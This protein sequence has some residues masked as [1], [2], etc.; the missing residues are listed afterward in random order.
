MKNINQ[1]K[2]FLLIEAAFFIVILG[3]CL[4]SLLNLF[5]NVLSSS[6]AVE[7]MNTATMLA[8]SK[9]EMISGTRFSEIVAEGVTAFVGDFSDYSYQ[10]AL[11]NCPDYA[12]QDECVLID[13]IVSHAQIP[14]VTLTSIASNYNEW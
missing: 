3:I 8:E 2:G 6:S 10:V 1:K 12:V 13:V 7:K 4:P 9:I 11:G 5:N 14:D